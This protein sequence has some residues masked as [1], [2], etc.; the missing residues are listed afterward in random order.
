MALLYGIDKT[1]R[2][3]LTDQ[4]AESENEEEHAVCEHSQHHPHR[5]DETAQESAAAHL[6]HFQE[7]AVHEQG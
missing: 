1:A 2:A 4:N 7:N 6:Y 3:R 5:H